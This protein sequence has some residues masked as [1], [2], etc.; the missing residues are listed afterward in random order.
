[1]NATTTS[2]VNSLA[3]GQNP[4]AL[5]LAGH[6]RTSSAVASTVR[7]AAPARRLSALLLAAGVAAAVVLTD[8]LLQDWAQTHMLASWLALW[9]VAAVSMSVLRGL[10]RVLATRLMTGLNQ[11]SAG[12]AR[13]RADERMW[14]I[15]K[16][17]AR[18][19]CDLQAAMSRAEE[20]AT[21]RA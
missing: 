2:L 20:V 13:R 5:T 8:D 19:M 9:A 18:L 12:V 6:Q 21:S 10:T 1:M 15:A 17:D 3:L 4:S 7:T 16:T 11:W 14:A